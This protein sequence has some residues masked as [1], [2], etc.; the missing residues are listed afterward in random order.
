MNSVLVREV[1][2]A[3]R[4]R[5]EWET[6][7]HARTEITTYIDRYHHRPHYGL[8]YRTPAEVAET[9]RRLQPLQIEAT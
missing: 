7:E 4:W 8:G 6:I 1:Q 2:E 3:L 9:W 5:S